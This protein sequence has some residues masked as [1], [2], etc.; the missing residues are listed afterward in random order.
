MQNVRNNQ[1]ANTYAS[2]SNWGLLNAVL[3]VAFGFLCAECRENYSS[4]LVRMSQHPHFLFVTESQPMPR[5]D[6]TNAKEG[7]PPSP[8]TKLNPTLPN[9]PN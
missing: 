9:E 6:D 8:K 2:P 5:G 7:R 4:T 3:L 1:P